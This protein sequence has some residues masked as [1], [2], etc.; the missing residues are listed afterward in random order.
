M[1]D[2]L[3][4]YNNGSEVLNA[5]TP[6]YQE[7]AVAKIREAEALDGWF[8]LLSSAAVDPAPLTVEDFKATTPYAAPQRMAQIIDNALE[9]GFL[10]GDE[11]SGF[12][13]TAEGRAVLSAF[14]DTA[15]EHISSAPILPA[16]EM[17][18]L[19]AILQ[20]L[21]E[22]TEALSYPAEKPSLGRSRWTDPG[23]D[24]PPAV[25]IDQFLT[26]L[27]L[28]RDDAHITAWQAKD[29][30]G[31][32]W[33]TLTFLWRDDAHTAAELVDKLPR[34]GY[35]EENYAA[36][37]AYLAG[38]G[39]IA[40]AGDSWQVTDS[41]RALRQDVEDE[42]DRLFFA[43]WNVLDKTEL[44]DLDDLLERLLEHLK[45]AAPVAEAV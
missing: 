35:T 21:V 30:D 2:K 20:R 29:V 25:R 39:W 10:T 32:S 42:T 16:A 14:F 19:A 28:F 7:V 44:V 15:R 36:S 40:P 5:F 41:G 23:P 6:F 3:T 4:I 43:G 13:L 27:Q 1:S 45:E 24:A 18:R 22:A 34:R 31:R 26:D 38:K 9:G 17:E 37:L 12:Q 33:E 8:A 11:D